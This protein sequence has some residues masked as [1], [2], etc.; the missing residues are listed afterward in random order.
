MGQFNLKT[1]AVGA[2]VLKIDGPERGSPKT[3]V[4]AGGIAEGHAGDDPH[5]FGGALAQHQSVQRPVDDANAIAVTR[6]QDQVGALRGFQEFRDIVRI[7]R[8]IAVHL[9]GEL[10][11]ALQRP[12]EPGAISAP[13]PVLFRAM[14]HMDLRMLRGECVGHFPGAV[15]R[16][17]VHHEQVNGDRQRQ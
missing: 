14:Q 1:V 7:V 17:I 6:A 15:G 2:D 10:V 8:Q 9:E 16:I 11:I 4:A 12:G 13:Q 3:L 5:I